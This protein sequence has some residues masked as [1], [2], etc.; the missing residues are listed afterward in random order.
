MSC[1]NSHAGL[2]Y[3]CAQKHLDV[4]CVVVS[5]CV[6]VREKLHAQSCNGECCASAVMSALRR[7]G[8]A[9]SAQVGVTLHREYDVQQL[10]TVGHCQTRRGVIIARLLESIRPW[11]LDRL[12]LFGT[13]EGH[14]AEETSIARLSDG[15]V[16]R[17][18]PEGAK[19]GAEDARELL[20]MRYGSDSWGCELLAS[21]RAAQV[22]GRAPRC[23]CG[24][25]F[26]RMSLR[27]HAS[28]KDAAGR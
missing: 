14:L 7:G 4:L 18:L 16:H 10:N 22:A 12:R 3:Q 13:E 2:A 17:C 21:V 11:Q 28:I 20:M 15:L 23:V 1:A 24:S 6:V 8:G 25:A 26:Q 9:P 19:A 5:A 27:A